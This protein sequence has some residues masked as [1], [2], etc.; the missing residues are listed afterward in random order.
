MANRIKPRTDQPA[1]KTV[2][3]PRD[4]NGEGTIFGG[5]ILSLIDQAAYVEACRQAR[6]QYVTVSFNQVEF[7]KPVFVGDVLTLYAHAT[8]IGRTSI[9]IHVEVHAQRRATP[10]DDVKVTEA[11]VVFVAVDEE[12][13]PVEIRTGTTTAE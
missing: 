9:T 8:R 3:M 1:I 12:C 13:R 7:H 6:H 10:E 4:T 2:M 5:V 11:S